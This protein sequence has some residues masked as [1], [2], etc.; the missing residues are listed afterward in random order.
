M[1]AKKPEWPE[2]G[3]LAIATV[4]RITD[5]GAYVTLDEYGKEGLLHISEISSSWIRNIRDYVR[6]G[7]KVVLKVLRV[8]TEK[9]H[10]DLSLRRVTKR[11]RIEKIFAFKRE[12]KAESLL[13]SAAEKLKVPK[14]EIAAAAA[15][16]EK[17]FGDVST[18]LEKAAKEGAAVLTAIGV[19]ENIAA[20]LEE[21]SKDKIRLP[22]VKIRGLLTL[23]CMGSKGVNV[24]RDAILNAEKSVD[25]RLAD[26][27][28]YVISAP[29]YRVEVSA[30]NYKIAEQALQRIADATIKNIKKNGGEG[31]F[32]REK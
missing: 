10:V 27:S 32:I 7:Q 1:A 6:E 31:S 19:P 15:L 5:Y 12:R 17:E 8:D 30:E 14:E 28:F 4:T 22:K 29:K 3:D 23:Q 2:V 16:M 18:G 25:P 26:V 21:I 13:R 11:E 24:I 20:A 9:S